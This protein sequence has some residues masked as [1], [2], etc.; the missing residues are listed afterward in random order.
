MDKLICKKYLLENVFPI[1]LRLFRAYNNGWRD[2]NSL[3][4]WAFQYLPSKV[5]EL[6]GK[7]F[8]NQVLRDS[9]GWL[10]DF[11]GKCHWMNIE[12]ISIT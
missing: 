7:N 11:Y 1:N 5:L 10:V 12:T 3:R 2:A 9:K 8:S 6:D 4:V